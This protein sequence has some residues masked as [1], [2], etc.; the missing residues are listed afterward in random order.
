MKLRVGDRFRLLK[1]LPE[2]GNIVTLKI[3]AEA[4]KKIALSEE[5]ITK[6]KVTFR[7]DR[8][9]W[10]DKD[11]VADVEISDIVKE[12]IKDNL[13]RLNKES[14]LTLADVPLWEVFK[15]EKNES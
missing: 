1:V 8:V 11:D 10:D 9:L 12:I 15:E 13:D 6:F 7:D 3:V 14:K 4:R 2:T 5:E